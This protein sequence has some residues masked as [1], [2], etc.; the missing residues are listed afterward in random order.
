MYMHDTHHVF[1]LHIW[2]RV[3][4][5]WSDLCFWII[6]TTY[7]ISNLILFC[8][9]ILCSACV[10]VCIVKWF[11]IKHEFKFESPS[12]FFFHLIFTWI[13]FNSSPVP[14]W[15]GQWLNIKRLSEHFKILCCLVPRWK[16]TCLKTIMC[17]KE[18]HIG[19][20]T[21]SICQKNIFY[22]L[23]DTDKDS[24]FHQTWIRFLWALCSTM[25]HLWTAVFVFALPSFNQNPV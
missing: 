9:C 23:L 4:I 15:G 7:W 22:T 11:L 3:R 19:Y 14:N 24:L 5:L 13:I 10:L 6:L 18:R 12:F 17:S 1:S 21:S 25:L 8:H 16:S 20:I 2:G